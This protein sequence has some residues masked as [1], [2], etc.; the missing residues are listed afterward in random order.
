MK[1]HSDTQ[2]RV[3]LLIVDDHAFVRMG[4]IAGLAAAS[5]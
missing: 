5:P 4:I 3:R 2:K 1:T